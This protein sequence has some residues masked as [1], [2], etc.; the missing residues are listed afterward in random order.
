M[1]IAD[2]VLNLPN[3]IWMLDVVRKGLASAEDVRI[4]VSFTRCSGLGL[5]VDPLREVGERGGRVRLL[6]STYQTVTQP[7]ALEALRRLP[8]VESRLQDGPVGFHAKFWWFRNRNSGEAWAGSSNLTKGGLAT[9]LEWNLRQV[10]AEQ[11]GATGRQFD[12]LW[13]RDDVFSL[14][15]EVLARYYRVY[16]QHAVRGL[17]VGVAA[18]VN[19]SPAAPNRA[20]LEALASLELLRTRGERRAAVIAATGVGKT[21]LAAFDVLRSGARTA[22][23]VSHR[24]EHLLQARRTF[25]R[26]FGGSRTLGVVG[27]GWN[28]ASAD[29]VFATVASL[30][31]RPELVAR[32]FDYL[33]IDEF[34]HAEAPSYK[35]LWRLREQA[36][37]LGIT[38][39]PERQDGHNVLEWCDWNIAYEVRLPEAIDRGWLLPFHYFGIA[40]ETVDFMRIPWRSSNWSKMRCRWR[41]ALS[42]SCGMRWNAAST[43]RNGRRSDSA[44]AGSTRTSWRRHFGVAERKRSRCSAT[45]RSRSER[46]PTSDWRIRETRCLG[47]SWRMFSTRASTCRS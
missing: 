43:V 33:V 25:G 18:D 21:Y 16:E 29:V 42:T 46:R 19:T 26:V 5:L 24:L 34:H 14:T 9:N 3:D 44:P 35:V 2:S 38:A 12:D 27:G 20:Q 39:T 15:D 11:L 22:L 37:L 17:G 47:C 36:F 41:L 30:R 23:Y 10:G 32:P 4:A 31:E 45:S 6:T 7:E 13:A 8:G 28:E 40:D 1:T